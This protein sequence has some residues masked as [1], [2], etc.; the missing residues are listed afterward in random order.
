[1]SEIPIGTELS[2]TQRQHWEQ[3]LKNSERQAELARKVLGIRAVEL[4]PSG[5]PLEMLGRV[6]YNGEEVNR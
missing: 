3:V 2:P 6:I 5:E 4:T 1:M